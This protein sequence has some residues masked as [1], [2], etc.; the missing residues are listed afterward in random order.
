MSKMSKITKIGT[1]ISCIGVLLWLAIIGFSA[2]GWAM[3]IY[4]L[5]GCDFEPSYKAEILRGLGIFFAP[6]GIILGY[7]PNAVG[8]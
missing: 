2:Y 8:K 7:L 3:N 6:M 1:G 5:I 4:Y